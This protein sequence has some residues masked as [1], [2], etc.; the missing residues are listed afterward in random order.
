MNSPY[1]QGI[2]EA[3]VSPLLVSS[4]PWR[5][6]QRRRIQIGLKPLAGDDFSS[7]QTEAIQR[8]G[9][10]TWRDI[11]TSYLL[12]TFLAGGITGGILNSIRRGLTHRVLASLSN[13]N[14]GG[15]SVLAPSF[16]T[17]G[18]ICCI[19]QYSFNELSVQRLKYLSRAEVRSHSA[20]ESLSLRERYERWSDSAN[21]YWKEFLP[22]KLSDEE[23]AEKMAAREKALK[24][25][26]AAKE[27]NAQKATP[28]AS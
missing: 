27:R 12:D 14:L 10:T 8:I 19:A 5:E 15:P 11:R 26:Q 23:Y 20:K 9:I 21:S 3:L 25:R 13:R 6:Y 17:S 7:E 2:R 1:A 18:L 22:R 16:I 28:Q 24:E 4:L